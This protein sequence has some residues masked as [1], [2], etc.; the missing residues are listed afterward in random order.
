MKFKRLL[1][2]TLLAL[3]LTACGDN[4]STEVHLKVLSPTGAP[5]VALYSLATDTEN[6]TTTTNPKDLIPNF[7]SDKYDIIVAPTNG[8][9]MQI[10]QGAQYKIAATVTFGNFYLLAS[11]RDIDQTLSAGDKVLVFQEGEVPDL[12][13][14]YLYGDLG[15]EVDYVSDAAA[16]KNA[17]ENDYSVKKSETETTYY[18]Y[19]YTAQPVV[20]AT[21]STIFKNIQDEFKA[22][23]GGLGI[24]Q[25]SIFVNNKANKE[26]VEKFLNKIEQSIKDGLEDPTL[27]KSEI[28]KLGSVK[29]QQNVFGVP[30]AM[31][32]KVTK[33]NNGF[34]LGFK[35]ANEIKNEIQSFVNVVTG[36]KFG[37][38]SEEAIYQ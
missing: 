29:E 18:D 30:G 7:K 3:T 21:D 13:F 15:L 33:A 10:K 38:L 34:S 12:V 24:T 37:E 5:A 20:S 32:F 8:G 11:G 31:A 6:Y 4:A 17:I 14:K 25:A 19:I 28:E 16:T 1:T 2:T 23:S 22:K 26:A 9:L 35:R 27:I 36:N